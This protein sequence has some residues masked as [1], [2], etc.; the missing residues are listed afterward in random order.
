M[1]SKKQHREISSRSTSWGGRLPLKQHLKLDAPGREIF[2][3]RDLEEINLQHLQHIIFE[4]HL[5]SRACCH[6]VQRYSLECRL[7]PQFFVCILAL[8]LKSL[9]SLNQCQ[10]SSEG[11]SQG[12]SW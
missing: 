11:N 9:E 1:R 2:R 3:L 12:T 4:A 7:S 8:R 6:G 5:S 10:N